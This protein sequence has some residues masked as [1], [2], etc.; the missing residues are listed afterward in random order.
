MLPEER[1]NAIVE[2]LAQRGFARV[3]DLAEV[4]EVTPVTIRRDLDQLSANGLVRRV[5]GGVSLVDAP[6]DTR[7]AAPAQ[8]ASDGAT[9]GM[10]VPSFGYY[11]SAVAHGAKDRAA[12]HGIKVLLR[13]SSYEN[14]DLDRKQILHL[15]D[16]ADV[17][18]LLLTVD[19]TDEPTVRLISDI[20]SRGIE[21][22]LIE[23]NA[24]DPRRGLAMESV[25]SDHRSGAA[26][27]VKALVDAGHTRMGIVCPR[28]SP[29]A[30]FLFAGWQGACEERGIDGDQ[31]FAESIDNETPAILADSIGR[32][33]DQCLEH[34][35]TALLV[36]A[37]PE[38]NAFVQA[39]Q[40][41]GLNVPGDLS[42]VSYDDEIASLFSPP[43][44]AVRPPRYTLGATAVDL[45]ATRLGDRE[46]P[47]HRTQISPRLTVRESVGAPKRA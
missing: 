24:V 25:T 15:V 30:P 29:T 44:T 10:L 41:R 47:V 36:H 33:L 38:A 3:A 17:S 42:V 34:G 23:R 5:H 16:N 28:R 31:T 45:L 35:T 6:E 4:L 7:P 26:L 37:D 2:T 1:R 20:R 27:A 14:P 32:V 46:R 8:P 9:I 11:W 39:A 18:G 21:V 12:D 43:M 13:E 22:V 40:Q 19:V